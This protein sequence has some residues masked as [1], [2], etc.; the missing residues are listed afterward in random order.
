MGD[1]FKLKNGTVLVSTEAPGGIYNAAQLKKIA[2]LCSKELAI[3]KATEDQR[4]ALFVKESEVAQ[5]VQQLK[6]IG[7]GFRNYQDGLH[8]PVS[9]LGELC[10]THEQPAL[11]TATDLTKLLGSIQLKSPLKIGINGCARC[12]TPCQT[13]DIAVIGE[14][15]GYRMSLGGKTSQVPELA[16]FFAEGIPAKELPRLVKKIVDLFQSKAEENESLQDVLE[17]CGVE[18]FVAALSPYSQDAAGRD[19]PFG[20]GGGEPVSEPEASVSPESDDDFAAESDDSLVAESDDGFAPESEET[21]DADESALDVSMDE[22]AL[23]DVGSEDA[24]ADESPVDDI[25]SEEEMSIEISEDA[26]EGLMA[27]DEDL[28]LDDDLISIDADSEDAQLDEI[29]VQSENDDALSDDLSLEEMR[30]D[31]KEDIAAMED[32]LAGEMPEEIG[33]E[34]LDFSDEVAPEEELP[35]IDAAELTS[36]DDVMEEDD[37]AIAEE[38]L[39][40]E[41][42]DVVTGDDE[43]PALDE[44]ALAL[45]DESMTPDEEALA[46]D[47]AALSSE[48]DMPVLDDE[49]LALAD[50]DLA[51]E[52]GGELSFEADESV[53]LTDSDMI[54][55]VG[56][57]ELG[58]EAFSEDEMSFD[59]EDSELNAEASSSELEASEDLVIEEEEG[60]SSSLMSDEEESRFEENLQA[61]IE[62]E[63]KL[64]ETLPE[65]TNLQAREAALSVLE[66]AGSAHAPTVPLAKAPAPAKAAAAP[67]KIPVPQVPKANEGKSGSKGMEFAGVDLEGQTLRVEF[68]SG[69]YVDVDLSTLVEGE[70]RPFRFGKK[71]LIVVHEQNGYSVEVDGMKMFYPLESTAA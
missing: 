52:D 53:E 6:A 35:A 12:C 55:E 23:D 62:E 2:E 34:T 19:D 42:D 46:L 39:A 63:K 41:E 65:D 15:S 69:A 1:L 50:D 33:E 10:D 25:I 22:V 20:M 14:G 11:S 56:A 51:V 37:L 64:L 43:L 49:T 27:A 54:E 13:L 61:S 40:L 38:A 3:V 4:L 70:S 66:N 58:E 16:T 28:T 67:A 32:D 5:V 36:E 59:D 48:D 18:D 8:Q 21:F 7:L 71:S 57:D 68:M 30:E 24:L 60:E 26:D 17:R 31:L 29:T 47:E 9:C 45:D 44:E